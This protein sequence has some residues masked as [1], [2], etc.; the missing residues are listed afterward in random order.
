[1]R[2]TIKSLVLIAAL[3]ALTSG[4]AQT[5]T[6]CTDDFQTSAQGPTGAVAWNYTGSGIGNP[7]AN[8]VTD[9]LDGTNTQNC[10]FT[11]ET[12]SNTVL[13]FGLETDWLPANGNTITFP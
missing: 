10:A 2:K 11:F 6:V 7:E 12:S 4:S 1:M 8:I 3:G 9:N 13:N 5:I